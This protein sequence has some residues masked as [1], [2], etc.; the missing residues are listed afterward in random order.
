MFLKGHKSL[1]LFVYAHIDF[2]FSKCLWKHILSEF[3]F[4]LRLHPTRSGRLSSSRTWGPH[5]SN[6]FESDV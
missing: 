1:S 3:E 6:Y 4:F 2:V 5:Y